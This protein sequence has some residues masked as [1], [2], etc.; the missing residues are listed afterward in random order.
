MSGSSC[1][2]EK[3]L[4]Q[5]AAEHSVSPTQ[6]IKWRDSAL[7]GA[8]NLFV[9]QDNTIA[10]RADYESRLAALLRADKDQV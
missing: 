1:K 7:E 3:T 2:E 10:L 6:I 8:S 9:R 5:A 4:A